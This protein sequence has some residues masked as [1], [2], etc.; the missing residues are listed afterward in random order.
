L[1]QGFEIDK[2]GNIGHS[3]VIEKTLHNWEVGG[4]FNKLL[5]NNSSEF[6]NNCHVKDICF[7][8]SWQRIYDNYIDNCSEKA[9]IDAILDSGGWNDLT[10]TP[11][12]IVYLVLFSCIETHL[13]RNVE[14]YIIDYN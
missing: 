7:E 13:Y 12:N 3:F 10:L 6:V 11:I 1:T 5:V 2:Y 9:C 4:A 8:E 14:V